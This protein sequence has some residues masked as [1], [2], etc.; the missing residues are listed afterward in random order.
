MNWIC[1]NAIKR[2][3]FFAVIV[4]MCVQAINFTSFFVSLCSI[5]CK[6]IKLNRVT[7]CVKK[8]NR[9]RTKQFKRR[10]IELKLQSEKNCEELGQNVQRNVEIE[11]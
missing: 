4:T 10:L 8:F 1:V 7:V 6:K 5:W 11:N 3:T 9:N 2:S